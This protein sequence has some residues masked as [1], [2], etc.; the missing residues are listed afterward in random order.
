MV[1]IP[2]YE[3][4]HFVFSNLSAHR[5]SYNGVEYP[6]V[7][8][9]FHA[10]KFADQSIRQQIKDS[11]SPLQALTLARQLKPQRRTDW[12]EVKVGILTE[13]VR[14]KVLQHKE[15]HEALMATGT[16]DIVEINPNDDFWGNGPDGNGQNRM[17][18][19]LMHIRSE[20][21]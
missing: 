16:D 13:I 21:I 2:Y 17:G 14:E 6:T 19:I 8:H 3:T 15:V 12:D 9:A 18:K 4:S 7:E 20:L 5:V 1:N 11:A 10:Q